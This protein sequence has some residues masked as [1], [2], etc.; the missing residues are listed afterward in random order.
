M[1]KALKWIAAIL[2]KNNV[3]F[4]IT[5]G[6][7]AHIYGSKRPIND[8]DIDIPEK[9]FDTIIRDINQ[10]II[11]GPAHYQDERW[12]LQLITLNYHGQEIDI[13]GSSQ[14]KIKDIRTGRW[15]ATPSDLSLAVEKEIMG[16]TVPVIEPYDLLEYKKMLKGDHQKQDLKAILTFLKT[17]K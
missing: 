13:G 1:K 9:Y 17:L 12:D 6:L 2:R 7:A 15:K 8:I 16:I 5:G 11:Y 10:Y 4:Q 3:P 14:T